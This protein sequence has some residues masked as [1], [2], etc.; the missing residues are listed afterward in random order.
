MYLL[1]MNMNMD[2]NM[3]MNSTICIFYLSLQTG[4][5]FAIVNGLYVS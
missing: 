4:I 3:D 1:Y 2:M 5:S